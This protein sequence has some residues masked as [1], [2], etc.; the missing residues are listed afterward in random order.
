[1]A[2]HVGFPEERLDTVFIILD[3]LD[4]IGKDGVRAELIEL[5]GEGD[6]LLVLG[7]VGMLPVADKGGEKLGGARLV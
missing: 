3:K 2:N 4:K 7:L 6:P 1:M 5:C